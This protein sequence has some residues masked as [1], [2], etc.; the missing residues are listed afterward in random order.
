M[1]VSEVLL[2]DEWSNP[3]IK[4]TMIL[5]KAIKR[6]GLSRQVSAGYEIRS[7]M[8][9]DKVFFFET[10]SL[11]I[12]LQESCIVGHL[13]HGAVYGMNNIFGGEQPAVSLQVASNSLYYEC[14]VSKFRGLLGSPEVSLAVAEH[15]AWHN[16]LV[17][18]HLNIMLNSNSYK[19]IKFAIEWFSQSANVF[20]KKNPFVKFVADRTGLS[21]G[22]IHAVLK[23]LKEGGYVEMEGG[24][25]L[26]VCKSLPANY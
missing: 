13:S 23:Q 5:M 18:S 21:K 16:R 15:I 17:T 10:G 3:P 6:L 20:Q 26:K 1:G 14:C 12:R 11:V 24:Y 19:K 22:H 4:S 7:E 9:C 8:Y 2:P 25:L